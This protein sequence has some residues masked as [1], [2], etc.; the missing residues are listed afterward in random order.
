MLKKLYQ[1][2]ED[3]GNPDEVNEKGPFSCNWPNTWLGD[4]F[5]Y[6]DHFF[7]NALWWGNHRYDENCIICE[8]NCDYSTNTCFD[9]VGTVEHLQQFKD[10]I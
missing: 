8:A 9:L 10:S 6:W 1:T 3:R 4:G 2:L 7:S 5:Y